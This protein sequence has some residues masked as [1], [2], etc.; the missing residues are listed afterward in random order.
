M[1]GGNTQYT[2]RNTSYE[3]GA[4]DGSVVYSGRTHTLYWGNTEYGI[5]NTNYE[6]GA[7]DWAVVFSGGTHTVLGGNTQYTPLLSPPQG[8]LR[9]PVYARL[10]GQAKVIIICGPREEGGN[11]ADGYLKAES[12]L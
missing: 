10:F 12:L 3:E 9:L 7:A 4:T 1:L 6:V 5:R 2:I 11:T 8:R